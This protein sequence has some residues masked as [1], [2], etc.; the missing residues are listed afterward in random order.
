MDGK[1]L[2]QTH[3]HTQNSKNYRIESSRAQSDMEMRATITNTGYTSIGYQETIRIFC[4]LEVAMFP[5]D[6]QTCQL[7]IGSWHYGEPELIIVPLPDSSAYSDNPG[8]LYN[9]HTLTQLQN[10]VS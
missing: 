7:H 4:R 10:G 2:T 8:N 9:T 5:Y 1:S 3:T 6:V